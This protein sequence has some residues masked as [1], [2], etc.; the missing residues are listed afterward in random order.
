MS[1]SF[2]VLYKAF[3]HLY[4]LLKCI[5]CGY[6]FVSSFARS[7]K[8]NV[9]NAQVCALEWNII[10]LMSWIKRSSHVKPWRYLLDNK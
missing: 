3:N 6:L 9:N 4:Q 1:L 2:I 10:I 8:L 5:G 7:A